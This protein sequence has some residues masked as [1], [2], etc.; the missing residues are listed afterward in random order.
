MFFTNG[1]APPLHLIGSAPR[2]LQEIDIVES[3]AS[4]SDDGVQALINGG[5]TS[6]MDWSGVQQVEE[7]WVPAL[8]GTFTRE[9]Y[10]RDAKWMEVP[11]TF[12]VVAVDSQGNQVGPSLVAH[13]GSDDVRKSSDDDWVRRFVARQLASGCPSVG[14]CAGATFKAEA[15]IQLRDA[16]DPDKDARTLSSS[17]TAL[18]VSFSQLPGKVYSVDLTQQPTG[19]EP[20]GYGFSV[21]LEPS[22]SP[23]NG[24]YYVPGESVSFRVTFRDGQ[25]NRLSPPGQLPTYADFISGQ[26]PS[27]LRYLDVQLSTRLYYALKHREGGM[28][29]VLSG[30]VDKL[31]T[32]QTVVDPTL[33]FGPQAPFATT[34]ADGYTAVAQEVP[35]AAI[36]FGGLSN[37][38]LWSVPVSDVVTFTIPTDAEAGT[39]VAAI[40]ARRDFAG[41]A[42][43]RG[44]TVNIQVGQPQATT[45]T[46]KT[47]CTSCHQERTAFN[48]I[49][50]GI[51]DRRACFGCHS[52]L[53]IEFDNVLD[54][55]VHT[56]H[57][58]S[59]R[60]GADVRQCSICHL[61][62]P[63]GPA[64]GL[65]P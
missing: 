47:T 29:A 54:I 14:N 27:G 17:T 65:L 25:G 11:S 8:D 3:V 36:I 28:L 21:D 26:G 45:F 30:P 57:D 55:R 35:P 60:F 61:T 48:T 22:S 34:A 31:K 15:L 38:S 19:S 33:L 5:T 56:I 7:I 64:R 58:R 18:H 1:Q 59:E 49:L 43:N 46:P 53:A 24:I 51:D 63:S 16:L 44:A 10:F 9:R 13:A 2:Y 4:P 12:A 39:Y 32:A 42:L 23:A 41:E 6:A 62:P 20:F 52:S 37:P 40:K 50:H